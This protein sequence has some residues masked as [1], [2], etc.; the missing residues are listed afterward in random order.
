[1]VVELSDVVPSLVL[2]E[3]ERRTIQA[4][5]HHLSS[6]GVYSSQGKSSYPKLA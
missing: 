5:I 3:V 2:K 4:L 6:Q 1:M